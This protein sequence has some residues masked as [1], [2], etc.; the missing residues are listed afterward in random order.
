[1]LAKI[2][3][4]HLNHFPQRKSKI[5]AVLHFYSGWFLYQNKQWLPQCASPANHPR[6]VPYIIITFTSIK[7]AQ[8]KINSI[9]L[10]WNCDEII[11]KWLQFTAWMSNGTFLLIP[12]H[13]T[14]C[15]C[16]TYS[17]CRHN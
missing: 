2:N 16:N 10:L 7:P 6:R 4:M 17:T 3:K 1:L 14:L 12:S 11:L 13:R 15:P 9:F 8:K 5:L